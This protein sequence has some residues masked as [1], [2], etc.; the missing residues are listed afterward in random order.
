MESNSTTRRL[1]TNQIAADAQR[2]AYISPIA[3]GLQG[4]PTLTL[5]FY[6]DGRRHLLTLT[7]TQVAQI[8][9]TAIR[10]YGTVTPDFPKVFDIEDTRKEAN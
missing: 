10:G 1:K 8:A 5:E 7:D 6:V 3:F 4:K 2:S 9:R